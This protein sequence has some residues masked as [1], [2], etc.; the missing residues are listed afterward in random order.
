[1][2]KGRQGH[3]DRKIRKGKKKKRIR[4]KTDEKKG[5]VMMKKKETKQGEGEAA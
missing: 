1:M 5:T 2:G 4:E 3:G